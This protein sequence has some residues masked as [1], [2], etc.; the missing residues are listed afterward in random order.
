VHQG[1]RDDLTTLYAHSNLQFA[2][3][4]SLYVFSIHSNDSPILFLVLD[5]WSERSFTVIDIN[6]RDYDFDIAHQVMTILP[7]YILR[8][9][10]RYHWALVDGLGG[11]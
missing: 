2:S 10:R 8:Q 9:H 5:V 1:G 11:M 7:V 4:Y 6:N 3:A